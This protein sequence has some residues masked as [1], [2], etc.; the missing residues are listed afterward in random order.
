MPRDKPTTDKEDMT[1]G[2]QNQKEPSLPLM[3]L[4]TRVG[5][6]MLRTEQGID[7]MWRRILFSP[8]LFPFLRWTKGHLAPKE[9][10]RE[11]GREERGD[12]KLVQGEKRRR[13]K[14]KGGRKMPSHHSPSL[15]RQGGGKSPMGTHFYPSDPFPPSFFFSTKEGGQ[16]KESPTSRSEEGDPKGCF[17]LCPMDRKMALSL[18]P[19]VRK[20]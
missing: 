12:P 15:R 6:G 8:V 3:Y 20:K 13:G 4:G 9:R 19:K 10:K 16:H 18:R 7:K 5:A 1:N 14:G 17:C 2:E 11:V